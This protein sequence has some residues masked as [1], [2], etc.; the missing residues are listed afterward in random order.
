MDNPGKAARQMQ[1]MAE[2]MQERSRR[3]T[4]LH[5]AM[6]ALVVT[7]TSAD[8]AVRV[9][10]DGNGLPTELTLTERSRGMDPERLSAELMATLRRAQAELRARVEAA[11]RE[12]VG[13]DEAGAAILAQYAQRFPDPEPAAPPPG[14]QPGYRFTEFDD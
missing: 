14:R 9:A 2:R 1:Q 8:G 13:D 7:E 6:S 10:V 4:E 11:T 12:S 5:T 3:F